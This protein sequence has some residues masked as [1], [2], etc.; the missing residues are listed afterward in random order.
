MLDNA[1]VI[2]RIV[3]GVMALGYLAWRDW[4][5]ALAVLFLADLASWLNDR[6]AP[7]GPPKG[8]S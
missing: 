1:R 5:L 3:A 2:L 8:Y 4:A 7:P 6:K